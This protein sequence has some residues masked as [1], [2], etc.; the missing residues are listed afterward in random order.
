MR[1]EDC[2]VG[3]RVVYRTVHALPEEGTITSVN[4]HF[5]FVCYGLPGSTP[6]ATSPDRL[7]LLSVE[8]EES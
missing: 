2:K 4:G 7:T 3:Q 6:K 1:L 5:A 8:R